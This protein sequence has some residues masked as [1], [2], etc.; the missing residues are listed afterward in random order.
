MMTFTAQDVVYMQMALELA[1]KGQFTTTPN[2]SVGCVLVKD[3]IIVGR[4]FHVKAGEAHAEVMALR[5]AGENAR[6]ATAYVTLEPCS[7]VGR[8]PPCAQGLI[9]AGVVKVV[10]AMCDPNP[11]VAGRGLRM[12]SDAGIES[13]VGLLAEKAEWLNRGFLKRMRTGRPY[14]QLKMAMSLDGRTAMA[15]GE[16]KWITGELARADVQAERAK[17]SAILSTSA[18]VLA[19]DPLLNVRWQQLPDKVKADYTQA[20][21]RQP[22]RVI[23]DSQHRVQP[24]HRLF[25]LSSPVWLVS[26]TARSLL[27][28]PAH[29]EQIQLSASTNALADLMAELGQRQINTLWIEAGA[30]LAGALIEA[31]LVDELIIYIA[32]KL[33]GDAARGLCKLPHLSTLAEASLWQLHSIEKLGDDLK[34]I[35]HPRITEPT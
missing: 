7:H 15:N 33:L 5:E 1:E 35:Y 26:Q 34:T 20:Q 19:D 28:F 16:S 6:G 11:Q 32:P 22:V 29:C 25:S 13:A 4:G 9:D 3:G 10:S 30:T 24:S 18:T 31:K 12:L 21:L 17:A 14:V 8:T 23:L 2:P 27:E